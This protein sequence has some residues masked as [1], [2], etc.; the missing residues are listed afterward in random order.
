MSIFLGIVQGIT[1][2]LPV[3]SSGHLAI[4]QNFF[5]MENIEESHL[6]FDVLLH[7]GTLIS[8]CIVYRKEIVGMIRAIIDMFTNR[9]KGNVDTSEVSLGRMAIMVVVA[10]LPL[11][12]VIFLKG[13][14]EQLSRSSLFIGV[15]LLITGCILFVSDKLAI[16]KKTQR[17]MSVK[18]AL[19]IGASQAIATVPG[20]SRSGVTI[21]T[22]LTMG[23][24]RE[25]AVNFS[26]LMSIPAIL[27]A[28]IVSLISAIAGGVDWSFFPIYLVGMA[29]A[30]VVGYFAIGLVKMLVSSNKFGK[31][32]YYCWGV[33]LLTIILSFIL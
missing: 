11:I 2:F 28:N 26:F 17:N 14:I 8:L 29:V 1:E 21:T 22:G 4:F 27:G 23:L 25:Y 30:A 20:L 7:F 5:K 6:F 12:V 24:S 13:Y 32:S 33:G 9:K 19:V 10:T 31:F 3:S 18:D 16:G 15:A